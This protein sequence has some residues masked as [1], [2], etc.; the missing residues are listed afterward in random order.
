MRFLLLVGTALLL[1]GGSWS[2]DLRLGIIGTDTSHAVVF[3]QVL[4]NPSAPNH[5][6][7][8]HIEVAYKG[9]SPDV[10]E[11]KSRIDRY[12]TELHDKW[13]VRFVD[14]IAE[15]CGSVDGILLESVDG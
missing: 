6:S 2:A 12:A 5:V 14:Q 11:S 10:E 3:T 13:S 1:T 15:M 9:G 8:A 4:N 7:G